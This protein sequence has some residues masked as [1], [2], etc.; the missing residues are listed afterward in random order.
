MRSDG[1]DDDDDDDNDDDDENEDGMG[2]WVP[3]MAD[4]E[5]GIQN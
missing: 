1:V 4:I 2:F 5:N 3:R